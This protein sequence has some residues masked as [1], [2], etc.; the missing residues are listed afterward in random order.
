MLSK[1]QGFILASF[2]L[3]TR[4]RGF[5]D[6]GSI[7]GEAVRQDLNMTSY[8][9]NHTENRNLLE[10]MDIFATSGET[11]IRPIL[12]PA[13]TNNSGM[14]PQ[15]PGHLTRSTAVASASP[16]RVALSATAESATLL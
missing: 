3:S 9:P 5:P 1:P 12:H 13:K 6:G 10:P 7:A 4:K 8:Q 2:S 15:I 16:Q 14:T 11:R